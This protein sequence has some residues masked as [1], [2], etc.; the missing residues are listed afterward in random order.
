MDN[1]EKTVK[2]MNQ[3][4][5]VHQVTITL[6]SDD[7]MTINGPTNLILQLGMMERAK[8]FVQANQ[9][10]QTQQ[11]MVSEAADGVIRDMKR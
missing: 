10:K 8:F 7:K 1:G 4:E 9:A 11:R 5:I 2:E 3:H 6:Y